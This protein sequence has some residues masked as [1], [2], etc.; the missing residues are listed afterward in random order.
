MKIGDR[1]LIGQAMAL[2]IA[3][4]L[5]FM[6]IV[7]LIYARSIFS[8]V[9]LFSAI[10][11]IAYMLYI[12]LSIYEVDICEKKIEVRNI[13]KK[14]IFEGKDFDFVTAVRIRPFKNS[15]YFIIV[16]KEG[17]KF[18]FSDMKAKSSNT[19]GI[20]YGTVQTEK[21]RQYLDSD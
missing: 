5:L 14:R 9:I 4:L 1:I 12:Y 8:V 17:Q 15:P 13:F 18:V 21:I 10:I 7:Y 6:P 3:I 11:V 19:K 20:D 2:F 16:F